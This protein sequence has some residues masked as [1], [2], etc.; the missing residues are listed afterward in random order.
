MGFSQYIC[1]TEL[2]SENMHLPMIVAKKIYFHFSFFKVDSQNLRF[3]LKY[4]TCANSSTDTKTKS[5]IKSRKS[6]MCHVSPVS[7]HMSHVTCHLPPATCHLSCLAYFLTY[8]SYD[9]VYV[10]AS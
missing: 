8:V 6:V 1:E 4:L 10:E 3:I 5:K 9:R 2:N 7:C